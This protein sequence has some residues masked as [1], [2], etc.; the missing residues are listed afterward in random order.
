MNARYLYNHGVSVD[1]CTDV[2]IVFILPCACVLTGG[3]VVQ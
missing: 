3:F 1:I 2:F